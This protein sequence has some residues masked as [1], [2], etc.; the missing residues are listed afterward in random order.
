M[1]EFIEPQWKAL[2]QVGTATLDE[3]AD[4]VVEDMGLT[5]EQT[6]PLHKSGPRTEYEYRMAWAR[7]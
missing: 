5:E 4:F 6:E 1:R 3:L 2:K 7:T